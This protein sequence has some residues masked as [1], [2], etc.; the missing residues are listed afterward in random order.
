MIVVGEGICRVKESFFPWSRETHHVKPSTDEE[1]SSLQTQQLDLLWRLGPTD[2]A[3]AWPWGAT[4]RLD[5]G[6]RPWAPGCNSAGAAKRSYPTPEARGDGR[7]KLP[8]LPLAAAQRSYPTSKKRLLRGARGLRGAT[9]RSKSEGAAVRRYPS[10]KVRS[11]GC[12]LLEQTWRD[13]PRP[14]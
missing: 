2:R 12:A 11:S 4:P 9:P 13:T 6:Q 1:G 14:R 8:P 3:E 7:E 5:Q 10:S